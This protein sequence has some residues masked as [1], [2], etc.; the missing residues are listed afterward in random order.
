MHRSTNHPTTGSLVAALFCF[1]FLSFGKWGAAQCPFDPLIE[2]DSILCPGDSSVLKTQVYD[3]YQWYRREWGSNDAVPIPGA[4]GQSLI[5]TEAD[6]LSFISVEAT[7]AG[8]TERSPEVLIDGW[9][10]ALP[11]IIH[12]GNFQ[13]DP[14]EQVFTICSGD[15][16]FLT[17]SSPYDTNITWYRD[18]T[19]IPGEHSS[20]LAVTTAGVYN[21]TGAP[22]ICP[23]YVQSPGVDIAVQVELCTASG[24]QP[25]MAS[26][27]HLSPN[28]TTGATRLSWANPAPANWRLLDALGRT[29][30][31][32][33]SSTAIDG[34]DLDLSRWPAGLYFVEIQQPN[35]RSMVLKV[36]KQ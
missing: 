8:C 11:V 31:K 30:D 33:S 23:N 12:S 32:G 7:L 9:V 1:L 35:R 25:S 5:V 19:P 16:M 18:G 3:A 21:V 10:F 15:T 14:N 6:V 22:A 20:T 34:L 2:G 36:F 4:T 17:L 29:L 28:P 13:F 26:H 24:E 27:V